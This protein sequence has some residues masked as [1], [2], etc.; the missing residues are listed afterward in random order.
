MQKQLIQI[1]TSA[2]RPRTIREGFGRRIKLGS[3]RFSVLMQRRWDIYARAECDENP[4]FPRTYL[5]VVGQGV[6]IVSLAAGT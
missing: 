1:D 2:M 5:V 6:T 3:C 4:T